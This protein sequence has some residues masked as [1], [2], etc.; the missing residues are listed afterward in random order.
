MSLNSLGVDIGVAEKLRSSRQIPSAAREK[1]RSD[2]RS[3]G[4]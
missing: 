2:P 1:R 3:E 4:V